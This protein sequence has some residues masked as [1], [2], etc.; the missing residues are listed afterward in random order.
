MN[1]WGAFRSHW[2]WCV[3]LFANRI[4]AR[5]SFHSGFLPFL[6]CW[7]CCLFISLFLSLPPSTSRLMSSSITVVKQVSISV[8]TSSLLS[9]LFLLS[10]F[11]LRPSF[12]VSCHF[13]LSLSVVQYFPTDVIINNVLSSNNGQAFGEAGIYLAVNLIS[14]IM[15]ALSAYFGVTLAMWLQREVITRFHSQYFD[16]T[17]VYALNQVEP[18]DG[19]DQRMPL[20]CFSVLFL[21]TIFLPDLRLFFLSRVPFLCPPFLSLSL[22][23][24]FPFSELFAWRM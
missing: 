22:F 8:A 18:I 16:Q 21:Q 11:L 12:F 7:P 5:G 24:F 17:L 23:T 9:A 13:F 20:S 6:F 3:G 10:S 2:W 4:P 1:G 14:S 19:I 15:Q